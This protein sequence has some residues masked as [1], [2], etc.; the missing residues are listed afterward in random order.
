MASLIGPC[1]ISVS[2]TSMLSPRRSGPPA[3]SNN[4]HLGPRGLREARLRPSFR[5]LGFDVAI[6]R[7]TCGLQRCQQAAG[8]SGDL[9]DRKIERRLVDLGGP[10]VS[11]ELADKLQRGGANLVLGRGR[12]EIEQR[13]DVPAH[14]LNVLVCTSA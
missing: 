1:P 4:A 6:A 8:R 2:M 10:R 13:T 14:R 7:R 3:G 12:R 11:A 5:L 9:V